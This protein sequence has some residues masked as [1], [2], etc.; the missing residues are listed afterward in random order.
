MRADKT[1][2]DQEENE[3]LRQVEDFHKILTHLKYEGKVS[4][5]KNVKAANRAMSR[6]VGT[7]KKH[8]RLQEEIIF[9]FL[10]VHIP[11]HEAVIRF[12]RSDHEDIKKNKD[13]LRLSLQKLSKQS[14]TENGKIQELGVYLICLL[15]HHLE[16]EKENIHKAIKR[17]LREDEKK[18]IGVRI[19]KWL[20][21]N[22]SGKSLDLRFFQTHNEKECFHDRRS[23]RTAESKETQHENSI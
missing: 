4:R 9:P 11:K 8:R 1:F 23:N 19:K 20:T 7:F 17:E 5:G 21:I 2:F 12:L 15:R 22:R 18:E 6:L 13:R 10:Q 3:I 16:L 14:V